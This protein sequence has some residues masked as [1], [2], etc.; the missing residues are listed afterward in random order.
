MIE[1]LFSRL[2]VVSVFVS[3]AFLA[4]A[5]LDAQDAPKAFVMVDIDVEK[6]RSHETFKQLI[7]IAPVKEFFSE[8][9]AEELS[10]SDIKRIRAAA[11]PSVVDFA[12]FGMQQDVARE[13]KMEELGFYEKKSDSDEYDEEEQEKRWAEID[14]YDKKMM[15]EMRKQKLEFFVQVEF[16]SSEVAKRFIEDDFIPASAPR[17]TV[18]GKTVVRTPAGKMFGIYFDGNTK[19]TVASDQYLFDV[20]ALKGTESINSYFSDNYGNAIRFAVDLDAVRPQIA[21]VKET[22]EVPVM[23]FGIVDAIRS[24]AM[25]IDLSNDEMANL[26]VNTT[27]ESNA[28][29]IASQ[30]NGLLRPVKM[31]ASQAAGQLFQEGSAEA[32]SMVGFF[33]GLKCDVDGTAA[34][35]NIDKPEGFDVMITA[36]V[37]RAKEAASRANKMNQFRQIA[38]GL[39]NAHDAY[40]RFPFAEPASSGL[41]KDLSWRVIVLP[42]TENSNLYDKFNTREAWNSEHNL[43]LVKQ[44]PNTFGFGEKGDQ[45]SVCWIKA[46]DKRVT[47][48]QIS[49]RDGTANTIMLMEN[50]KKVTWSKPDDLTIDEAVELVKN[51]KDGEELIVVFYDASVRTIS[52]KIDLETFK[53]MLTPF[54]E[55][56]IDHS[57]IR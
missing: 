5:N 25:S 1:P 47:L 11:A 9:D 16:I 30:I 10:V 34:K 39:H 42:F 41:S 14:A 23:V 13:K 33:K 45:T 4:A 6:A 17:E 29:L 3:S 43:P 28:E 32:K 46:T 56:R 20:S 18:N 48:E 44:M 37:A 15:E 52:N 36:A 35:M 55:E 24:G 53:A 51:L 50:P 7:D 40:K 26:V 38:I 22:G 12:L 21:K 49:F 8:F 2:C 27:N 57:K 54:G 19:L 31:Q